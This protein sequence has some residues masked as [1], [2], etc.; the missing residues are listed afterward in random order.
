M[1]LPVTWT[2]EVT[3]LKTGSNSDKSERDA[4]LDLFKTTSGAL[5]MRPIS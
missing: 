1:S 5:L 2:E 3:M 4:L